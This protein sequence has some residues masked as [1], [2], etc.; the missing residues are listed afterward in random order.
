M[1][2]VVIVVSRYFGKSLLWRVIMWWVVIVASRYVLS[3]YC[4]ES[5]CSE[6]LLWRV[7]I[8]ASRY[9]GESLL[10]RIVIQLWQIV[11]WR[12]V[13]VA[14]GYC[15]EWL[16]NC[17]ESLCGES[18]LW[19]IIILPIILHALLHKSLKNIFCI[20]CWRFGQILNVCSVSSLYSQ[21]VELVLEKH[22]TEIM[23]GRKNWWINYF[24]L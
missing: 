12:V 18:L 11:M 13:I 20:W 16:F 5:L 2:W 4:G 7:I 15:G 22:V 6:W 14:S 9:C 24:L 3:G 1:W 8:L 17:G 10:W 21:L 19:R 23:L